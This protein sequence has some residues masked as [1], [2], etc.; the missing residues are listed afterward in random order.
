M[1]ANYDTFYKNYLG[2]H[3][4]VEKNGIVICNCSLRD[5]PLNKHFLYK[6]IVTMYEDRFIISVSNEIEYEFIE[7]LSRNIVGK[8][9]DDIFQMMEYMKSKYRVTF[10]H[11]MFRLNKNKNKN[12]NKMLDL[13]GRK[14][15]SVIIKY[16]KENRKFL[17]YFNNEPIGYCKISDLYGSYGKIVVWVDER[18]R[19]LGIA[20][21]LLNETIMK[22][23]EE[24]IEPMYLVN[25]ENMASIRLAKKNGFQTAQEE[26]ILCR[27]LKG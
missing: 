2:I 24:K 20:T 4:A 17:A 5:I 19:C 18:Y 14:K 16:I 21:R 6:M 7:K 9:M 13:E 26:I 10:L 11:R 27:C 12:K 8:S 23:E 25:R 3:N 15:P 1:I 22:C